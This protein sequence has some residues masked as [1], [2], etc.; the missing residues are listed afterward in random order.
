MV[1]KSDPNKYSKNKDI[2]PDTILSNVVAF[3]RIGLMLVGI[4][5]IALELF[6]EDGWLKTLLSKIFQTSASPRASSAESMMNSM[7]E[8]TA[9]NS[10]SASS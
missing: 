2:K 1:N 9:S 6:R 10:S 5:G 3:G 8:A 4:V 7:S